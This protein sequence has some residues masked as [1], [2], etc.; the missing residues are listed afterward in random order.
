MADKSVRNLAHL[1]HSASTARVLNLLRVAK[2]HG[3][4]PEYQQNPMFRNVVLNRSI[5]LKHRLR[6]D[7][8][9]LFFDGRQTA[10]KIILPIDGDDLKLGGRS[11]FIGQM[12]F[13]AVMESMFGDT[14]LSQT[15]DHQML[16]ILDQ[17]PSLDP[18]LLRE[19]LKR[20]QKHPARVY[21]E[22]S[23]ADIARMIRF[24]EAEIQK[25]IDLCFA[26][27][28]TAASERGGSRLVKKIL[29]ITVDED[30]EPLRLTLR[31]DKRDY[32]EGVFCWKGFLYY[33][34]T[35]RETMP[36]ISKVVKAIGEARP[37][38]AIDV[39]ARTYLEKARESLK[40][41]ILLISETAKRSLTVYDNAFAS[42]IDGRP[43]AFRDFLLSA[44]DMFTDL[45]ER[46]GAVNHI[47]SF[48]NFR[49][50]SGRLP[51][52]TPEE[53]IDIFSDFESSL[54]FS[55]ALAPARDAV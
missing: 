44:P 30:T 50:P 16:E 43:Q 12:N 38:G 45:G 2:R 11:V 17:L 53:L 20:R 40:R 37:H 48:W 14:W 34:W 8:K 39:E 35:L 46:L 7:E 23:D 5:I 51:V 3:A 33:K 32:Q 10:T 47:V 49:F 6:R 24:V 41:S 19:Q 15:E 52:V 22:I 27:S 1:Q 21:F 28:S 36:G 42:L 4:D 31:L 9:E 26:G 25:L 55:E 13:D 18:F 29:S 54:S